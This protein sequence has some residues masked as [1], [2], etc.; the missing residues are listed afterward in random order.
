MGDMDLTYPAEAETFRKEVRA[1]LE[2]NLP[3]GWFDRGHKLTGDEKIRFQ[4]EWTTKLFE[5]GWICASWPEEYGGKGLST[6]EAVVASEEFHKANAPLRADFFGDTLVGPTILQWGSEEQKQYF[7]P[8]ILQGKIAWCEGF[9]EPDAGSDLAWLKTP[10]P[11][12]MV[13]SGSS[14]GRRSGR[15]RAS[16]PTTSSFSVAPTRTRRSTRAS[17]TC[18]VR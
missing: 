3:E 8:L 15:R 9:S 6:M 2:E 14:T 5:G 1:W 11:S 10:R 13:T 16:S 17:P 4:K 7:L 12:S 18:C